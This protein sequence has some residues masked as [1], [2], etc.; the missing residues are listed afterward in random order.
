VDGEELPR[1][2]RALVLQKQG[3]EVIAIASGQEANGHI[4]WQVTNP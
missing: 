2:F 4:V 1:R 3:Y